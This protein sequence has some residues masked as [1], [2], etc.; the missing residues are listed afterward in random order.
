M[1]RKQRGLLDLHSIN[2]CFNVINCSL[3]VWVRLA[4]R[5]SILF[6]Y[7]LLLI[8]FFTFNYSIYLYY[9]L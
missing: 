9:I 4:R 5:N 8:Y 1:G 6:I 2:K 7:L 3:Y